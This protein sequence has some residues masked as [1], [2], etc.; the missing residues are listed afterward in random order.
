MPEYTN[1]PMTNQKPEQKI[2]DKINKQLMALGWV[3][4]DKNILSNIV[5][6]HLGVCKKDTSIALSILLP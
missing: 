5:K 3:V 1:Y 2:R 6:H 4:G